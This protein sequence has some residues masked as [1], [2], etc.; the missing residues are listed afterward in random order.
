MLQETLFNSDLDVLEIGVR[1]SHGVDSDIE[2]ETHHE[3]A[4][5]DKAS[6]IDYVVLGDL[7]S[8]RIVD[9]FKVACKVAKV[10][11]LPF[12][13]TRDLVGKLGV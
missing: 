2:S 12:N 1:I 10:I 9:L 7:K 5:R 6:S 3:L 4:V 8:C 13:E 11:V